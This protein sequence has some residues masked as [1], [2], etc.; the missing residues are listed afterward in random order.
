MAA[1]SPSWNLRLLLLISSLGG[2][3]TP[4]SA[5]LSDW[6]R[7]TS[8][9]PLE[10]HFTGCVS[11]DQET[12]RCW[13][14]PG[15]FHNLSSPGALRVFYLKKESV[16]SEWKECP[17]YVYSNRECFFDTNDTSIWITYCMQLRSQNVT[18]YNEDDCFTVENIVRP[19]PPVSLNWTLLNMSPSG[20]SYDV[21]VKWKPPPNADIAMGWMRVEYEIQYREINGTHWEA[22]EMQ[23][24][25]QQTIFGLLI[26]KEYEVHIRCRMLGF[27]KFGEFSDS[28]FIQV[29]EV[30][31]RETTYAFTI[32]V[33]F[34]I[35]G[36]LV[37]IM[38]I[39]VSQQHRFMMILL[40]PVPA[41]K[42][43]GIDSEMLKNGK[44]DELNL[45]LSGGGMGGLSTYA[46]DF[47][48]DE[49]WVEFIEVDAEDADTGE[50]EDQQASDTQRLLGLP[51]PSSQGFSNTIS[52]PD[53]DSGRASCYDP[54]LLEQDTLIPLATLRPG[55]PD[56]REASLSDVEAQKSEKKDMAL[57]QTQNAGPQTWV[58]TDFYAQ[59]SNVMPSGGVVLSP[60]QQLRSQEGA[61][62][63]QEETQKKGKDSKA[64]DETEEKK[65]KEQQFELLVVD[66]DG[67]GYITES[68]AQQSS[69]PIISPI[70]GEGHQTLRPQPVE[71]KP[72]AAAAA[73]AEDNQSP[74]I[75]SDSPF[76][77]FNAPVSDYTVVQEVDT[78]HSLLLN[79]PSRQSPPPC[80]PQHPLKSLPAM[81]VGYVTPDLLGNLSP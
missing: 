30:P 65:Q 35:V 72:A 2:L 38:L 13:W 32:V 61:S 51:Q 23:Q 69:T 17:H 77:Q 71:P 55:P 6:S 10:P 76:T 58:N 54:D 45:I 70:P 21:M 36:V 66:P 46:P 62:A 79:P 5:F 40:P 7:W 60:G 1:S 34:G 20:V 33:V 67:S 31:S 49:P 28:V 52:F 50:K 56:D 78:Q 39:V 14:S 25:N 57:A 18:F 22:L 81:P 59:V 24:H 12:F 16:N 68:N 80:L 8:S 75:V 26:E 47:Y 27:S 43:K 74:Y 37:L 44:L 9:A 15:V 3:V 4:G 48:Q 42:I 19:D 29:S 11:R 64:G 73:A 63:M 53:D 41:P